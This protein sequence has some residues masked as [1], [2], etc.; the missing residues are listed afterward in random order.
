METPIVIANRNN[1][2]LVGILHIPDSHSEGPM[3]VFAHGFLGTKSAPHRLFIKMARKLA[4]HGIAS[5]RFDY[6]GSGDSEG[7]FADATISS[8]VADLADALNF[9]TKLNH[10]TVTEVGIIGYSLGGCI[11]SLVLSNSPISIS[12]TVM[13]APVSNPF[14]NIVHIIG[15]ERVISGLNGQPI[16]FDGEQIGSQFIKELPNTDPIL[17]IK[18]YENPVLIIHGEDDQEV[19]LINSLAYQQVFQHSESQLIIHPSTGHLFNT[20]ESENDL[21]I[22]TL[23]WFKNIF[24]YDEIIHPQFKTTQ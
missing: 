23:N 10:Y 21:I 1:K 3:V 5:L 6:F 22:Q 7:E 17:S 15:E 8:E 4:N 12:S 14:W 2:K 18:H 19:L 20:R 11:A 9:V 24:F 13:W 16:E